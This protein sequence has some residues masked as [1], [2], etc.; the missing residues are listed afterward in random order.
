MYMCSHKAMWREREAGLLQWF[1]KEIIQSLP[2][3]NNFLKNKTTNKKPPTKPINSP[4]QQQTN[5][6]SPQ[7]SLQ[8]KETKTVFYLAMVKGTGFFKII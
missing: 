2:V 1:L 5:N 7:N 6:P 8:K 3:E 4:K